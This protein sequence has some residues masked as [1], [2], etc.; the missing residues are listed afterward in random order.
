MPPR[1]P[2]RRAP[3]AVHPTAGARPPPRA[4]GQ[5]G[6]R[7]PRRRAAKGRR[8]DGPEESPR[9]ICAPHSSFV[10]ASIQVGAAEA[11]GEELD[12]ERD[13]EP[14]CPPNGSC[15]PARPSAASVVGSPAAVS[16]APAG[17]F[18]P[19]RWSACNSPRATAAV[20]RSTTSGGE[21]S[22]SARGQPK[23]SGLVPKTRFLPPC[24][25][26]SAGE[27]QHAKAT[28]PCSDASASSG[29]ASDP[30]MPP[31]RS[32]ARHA[33]PQRRAARASSGSASASAGWTSPPPASTRTTPRG[34]P[35]RSAGAEAETRPAQRARHRRQPAEAVRLAAVALRRH[36]RRRDG[37]AG[38]AP[39]RPPR[40]LGREREQPLLGHGG[41]R[42]RRRRFVAA[43]GAV[44]NAAAGG[45]RAG[46]RCGGRRG[47]ERRARRATAATAAASPQSSY[48]M[49]FA[50]KKS[51]AHSELRAPP[52]C[53]ILSEPRYSQPTGENR[54]VQRTELISQRPLQRKLKKATWTMENWIWSSG[55][56]RYKHYGDPHKYAYQEDNCAIRGGC[57]RSR[58]RLLAGEPPPQRCAKIAAS[59]CPCAPR[60]RPTQ[61][62]P[63]RV[64]A[65]T[66]PLTF[67]LLARSGGPARRDCRLER[68]P[69]GGCC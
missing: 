51:E 31:T 49:R 24:A 2:P 28:R 30:T 23:P 63:N 8:I 41:R 61:L 22:A 20:A 4:D 68:P 26:I 47:R 18:S 37:A 53:Q 14:L 6:A 39:G 38:A 58:R 57:A 10:G 3:R 35:R 9:F 60:C 66:T 44:A 7:P 43:Q 1:A 45:W 69:L 13:A 42:A 62:R 34:P 64:P 67:R 12:D 46:R 25:A 5:S 65:S 52:R 50:T 29:P 17:S 15:A 40:R 27:L 33:T 54:S 11:G 59:N 21:P 36:E 16:A 32:S 48:Q 19:R 56:L 55:A